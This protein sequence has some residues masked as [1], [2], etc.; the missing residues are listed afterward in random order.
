MLTSHPRS[1][2]ELTTL[3]SNSR[4]WTGPVF[5]PNPYVNAGLVFQN[6]WTCVRSLVQ[7]IGSLQ[8][9]TYKLT[10]FMLPK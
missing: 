8:P 9:L 4:A 7:P 10:Y 5:E 6:G 3:L 2:I 1:H